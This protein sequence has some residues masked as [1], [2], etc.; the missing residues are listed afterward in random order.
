MARLLAMSVINV[1]MSQ[2]F[3]FRLFL[4]LLLPLSTVQSTELTGRFSMLGSTAQAEQGDIGFVDADNDTL[5]ADQQ[6]LRLMLDDIQD[7]GEWAVHLKILRQHL[8]NLTGAEPHSSDLFRYRDLSTDWLDE[9][10]VNSSTRIGYEVDRAAYKRRFDKLTLGIGRQPID[11]GSGR[12]WQPLNVFGAFAPTDL[13]T[14][15][16]AGIDAAV[17]DW[18]P[19]D[20]SSLTAVYAF[21]PSDKTEIENSTAVYYRRQI[22]WQVEMSLLAGQVIGNTVMGVSLEGDWKGVGWRIEGAHN[23][24]DQ[25]NENTFFWIAGVDYQFENAILLAVEW[26]NHNGGASSETELTSLTINQQL[27]YGLQQY[28]GSRVL[29]IS[30]SKE[31]TPLW[32]GSY[33]AL[34]SVLDD[35]EDQL[36]TSL[37]HQFTATYSV[38]N[39]SDLLFSLLYGNGKKLNLSGMPQ[40]EFGHIPTS[41]TVRLR[42]YF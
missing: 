1:M 19:S 33:T 17:I 2:Q 3:N 23:K 25:L 18:Y 20:F 10:G 15:F 8:N 27:E 36:T 22:A 28:L 4:V 32:H 6:S 9:D 5:T 13:D 12:L 38:S 11:W 7:N 30:A 24:L 29:G 26:Y 42:F 14:D 34:V 16:K 40:S 35:V 37:L 39:E 31:L 41:M 21:A